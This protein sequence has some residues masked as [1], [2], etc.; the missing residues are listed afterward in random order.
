MWQEFW[1]KIYK[2]GFGVYQVLNFKQWKN[3]SLLIVRTGLEIEQKIAYDFVSSM[4]CGKIFLYLCKSNPFV[5]AK[6][7]RTSQ[8][9]TSSKCTLCIRSLVVTLQLCARKSLIVTDDALSFL[10]SRNQQIVYCH[11][12]FFYLCYSLATRLYTHC[13]GVW[14]R[15]NHFQRLKK[16]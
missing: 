5:L 10:L 3:V 6:D 2:V 1:I 16:F 7:L 13:K 11:K 12:C 4:Q 8:D 9:G 15:Q 14:V